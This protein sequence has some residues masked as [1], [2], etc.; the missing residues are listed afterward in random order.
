MVEK[1]ERERWVWSYIVIFDENGEFRDCLC[2][3]GSILRYD[4]LR[5]G[6]IGN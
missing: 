5:C 3:I 2:D 4:S 6:V 1:R